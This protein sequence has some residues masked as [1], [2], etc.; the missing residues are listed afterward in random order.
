MAV[1]F[2]ILFYSVYF[3]HVFCLFFV[4]RRSFIFTKSQKRGNESRRCFKKDFLSLPGSLY[5]FLIVFSG[6][7]GN[8]T[9]YFGS[10]QDA[11]HRNIL[12]STVKVVS[13]GKDIRAG[14]A[15]IA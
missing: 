14:Q 6:K 4:L 1:Y 7:S 3:F 11:F 13:A 15:H 5:L 12:V 8:F 10:F 9:D 2:Y